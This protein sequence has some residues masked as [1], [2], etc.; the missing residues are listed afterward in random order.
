MAMSTKRN[1]K[2][3]KKRAATGSV[4]DADDDKMDTE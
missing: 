1:K 4:A 3:A 2:K